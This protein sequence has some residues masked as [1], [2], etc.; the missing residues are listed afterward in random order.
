MIV[1]LDGSREGEGIVLNGA[2]Y[3]SL[4]SEAGDAKNL[5]FWGV[6]SFNQQRF[7][8]ILCLVYGS[9]PTNNKGLIGPNILPIERAGGCTQEYS[10]VN[11]AWGQLL[12]PYL[13]P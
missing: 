1:L 2:I 13:I 10:R 11:R 4:N 9:N 5:A 8:D 6:H 3:F 7:Y 12:V